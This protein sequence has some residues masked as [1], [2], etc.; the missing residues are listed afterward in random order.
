MKPPYNPQKV[1]K[2]TELH[3]LTAKVTI[4]PL[5]AT[6]PS[7]PL[8]PA[9]SGQE[10]PLLRTFTPLSD[11]KLTSFTPLS[12]RFLEVKAPGEPFLDQQ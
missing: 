5:C 8:E 12:A 1:Q 10:S 7:P 3:I 4:P 2:V 11:P 9:L 6:P